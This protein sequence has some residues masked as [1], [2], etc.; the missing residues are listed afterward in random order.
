MRYLLLFFSIFF[1]VNI[2]CAT[3][4]PVIERP[5]GPVPTIPIEAEPEVQA[6]I[7]ELTEQELQELFPLLPARPEP[8]PEIERLPTE[9]V[10][11]PAPETQDDFD[12]ISISQEEF[13][14]T[15]ADIQKLILDLNGIIRARN[16]N[17]WLTYLSEEYR[18]R[19]NSREFLNE[20]K[21]RSPVL[22]DRINNARDYF[23]YVV[24]PSRANDRVDD[25]EFLTRHKVA[26]YTLD[27]N[28][29]RLILY[30]LEIIDNKWMIVH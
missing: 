20:I 23:T 22:G 24:V 3:D 27:R 2:S 18:R 21:T 9:S 30:D 12:P 17:T 5:E 15:K 13:E 14:T 29:N 7:Q 28:G 8:V 16:Y 25:I 19:I 26:A 11:D 6:L 10:L 4:Q 1:L